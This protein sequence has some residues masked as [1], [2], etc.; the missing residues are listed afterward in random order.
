MAKLNKLIKRATHP[1]QEPMG[2][3]AVARTS[4][5]SMLLV[6]I[7]SD[8]WSRATSDAIAA[9]AD[10]VVLQGKPGDKDISD[11]VAA[12]DDRPCGVMLS[13]AS[14]DALP[15]LREAKVDF[16]V[17]GTSAPAGAL[18]EEELAVVLQLREELSDVQLRTLEPWSLDAI[19]LDREGTPATILRLLDVQRVSGQAR[20]P[21]IIQI[22]P[23]TRQD[24]LMALRDSG[25]ALLAVEMKDRG[26]I[27]SL[28]RLRETIDALPRPTP[29]RAGKR[30][31][32][33]P[34]GGS[35]S[36]SEHGHEEEDDE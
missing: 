1:E 35:G 18:M 33:L 29:R 28:K 34:S 25:V 22:P 23:D 14:L 6:A 7:A 17:V 12:A 36:T 11:A 30:E 15:R 20:K 27:D 13:D 9:G 3:G 5:P 26:A 19:Y 32:F 2:F 31:A 10:I 8:H 24:E 4:Q 16:V 21:L